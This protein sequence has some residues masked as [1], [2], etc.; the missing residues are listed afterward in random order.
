VNYTRISLAM[1]IKSRKHQE[2]KLPQIQVD[3]TIKVQLQRERGMKNKNGE[4]GT[5]RSLAGDDGAAAVSVQKKI[6]S[7]CNAAG[8][9]GGGG[10]VDE[11]VGRRRASAPA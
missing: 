5:H 2:R 9:R 6:Q 8:R 11:D 4:G 1:L 7:P 10:V 3:S